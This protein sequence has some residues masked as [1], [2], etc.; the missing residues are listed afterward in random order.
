MNSATRERLRARL[1]SSFELPDDSQGR[2]ILLYGAGQAAHVFV[3]LNPMGLDGVVVS[4]GHPIPDENRF[5]VPIV[6]LSHVGEVWSDPFFV[7][8][9]MYASDIAATLADRGLCEGQDFTRREVVAPGCVLLYFEDRQ[10]LEQT[11]EWMNKSVTYVKLRWFEKPYV[12]GDDWDVLTDLDGLEAV[13]ARGG[14]SQEAS[15]WCL[16]LKWSEPLGFIDE[17]LYYPVRIGAEILEGRVW[18]P[19]GFW[20]VSD[21]Q[22]PAVF[23]Y[24]VVF[25]KGVVTNVP[26]ASPV[27][28]DPSRNER[29]K[30]QDELERLFSDTDVSLQFLLAYLKASGFLPPLSEARRAVQTQ[31]RDDLIELLAARCD[32]TVLGGFLVRDA[33]PDDAEQV[34]ARLAAAHGWRRLA[35]MELSAR[36]RERFR[37]DV[38]GGCGSRRRPRQSPA[39]R[40]P[41]SCSL[42]TGGQGLSLAPGSRSSRLGSSRSW[43]GRRLEV[44][45]D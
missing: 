22:Y 13:L 25:Q 33:A 3:A 36:E 17:S 32:E 38:R 19:R 35:C 1:A 31:G 15:E 39:V 40:D 26:L 24:H 27:R 43:P 30:F 18:D 44:R 29:T 14:F 37:R 8:A 9:S 6:H 11:I 28:D 20:R 12:A 34:L 5:G 23:A 4:D 42:P 10:G 2:P 16:D 41:W 21:L 7:I 45:Q